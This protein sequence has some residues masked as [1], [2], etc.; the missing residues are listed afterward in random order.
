MMKNSELREKSLGREECKM[1]SFTY[2]TAPRTAVRV[3]T[4]LAALENFPAPVDGAP[5]GEIPMIGAEDTEPGGIFSRSRS[6]SFSIILA[7]IT[8]GIA[9]DGPAHR[10]HYNK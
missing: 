6:R 10:K 2:L 1:A 4:R 3:N 7:T 9:W 8:D 5:G